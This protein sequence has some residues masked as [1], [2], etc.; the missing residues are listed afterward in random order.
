[1][2]RGTDPSVSGGRYVADTGRQVVLTE[3]GK[4]T[5]RRDTGNGTEEVPEEAVAVD[6]QGRRMLL[7]I[8]LLVKL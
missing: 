6:W 3:E 2:S 8:I 7:L 1:M 5:W 4:P